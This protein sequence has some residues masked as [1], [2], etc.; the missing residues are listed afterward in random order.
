MILK[1]TL[2]EHFA[3]IDRYAT[4]A[5]HSRMLASN[6]GGDTLA[7]RTREATALRSS[8]PNLKKVVGHIILSH[9][10]TLTDLSDEQWMVALEIARQEH[11]LRDAAYCAVLHLEKKHR[12][13]HLYFVRCRPDGSVVSDSQSY[14]K[15]ESAARRIEQELGLPPPTPVP[16]EKKVGD[17]RRSDNATRRGRRKQTEGETF[18]ETAELS[19][20]T[21][22]AIASSSTAEAFEHE[23]AARGIELEWTPNRAG[24]KLLPIGASTC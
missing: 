8:R 10:P 22:E 16:T 3:G 2:G 13:L 18:M 19:R 7:E 23:L 21:F 20:L 15:N 9:D 4:R 14:R 12:H 11:N 24:I 6:F 5:K 1:G 17:R